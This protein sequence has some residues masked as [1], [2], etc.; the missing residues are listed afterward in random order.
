ML[1]TFS[2]N[3]TQSMIDTSNEPEAYRPPV[4][5][6]DDADLY[7]PRWQ[8]GIGGALAGFAASVVG[9]LGG[10]F[11]FGGQVRF[12][13]MFFA[14]ALAGASLAWVVLRRN[15]SLRWQWGLL[16]GPMA[17]VLVLLAAM[18]ISWAWMVLDAPKA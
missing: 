7:R 10:V 18:L 9:L 16:L 11:R 5:R 2:G 13:P 17:T 8:A 4:A 1:A 12:N 6:I 14:L 15:R 3:G